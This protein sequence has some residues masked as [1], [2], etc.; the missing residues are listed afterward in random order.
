MRHHPWVSESTTSP[1]RTP[2]EDGESPPPPGGAGPPASSPPPPGATTPPDATAGERDWGPARVLAGLAALLVL[3]LVE[4]GIVI[5]ID[6][7]PSLAPRALATAPVTSGAEPRLFVLNADDDQVWILEPTGNDRLHKADSV[8]VT[9][10]ADVIAVGRLQSAGGP[11]EL[12][13]ANSNSETVQL[14]RERDGEFTPSAPLNVGTH[15]RSVAIGP[16][17]PNGTPVLAV[18]TLAGR[19]ALFRPTGAGRLRQIANLSHLRSLPEAIAIGDVNGDSRPDLLVGAR[20]VVPF[21]ARPSGRLVAEPDRGARAPTSSLALGDLGGGQRAFALTGFAQV[22]V[23]RWSGARGLTLEET[24]DPVDDPRAVAVGKLFDDHADLAV[25]SA[26]GRI[27]VLERSDDGNIDTVASFEAQQSLGARLALQV[28]LAATLALV[29]FTLA[30]PRAG[31]A[32]AAVLG[33]RR[34]LTP[35]W[36][37]AAAAYLAYIGC[38]LVLAALIHPQQDDVTRDLGFGEGGV[39]DL[40]SLIL[41]VVAAP[42]TEEI[43]FR[44]FLFGGLRRALPFVG[45]ALLSGTI[46]GLFHFTGVGSWGVVIQL[47]IF[48]VALAWVYERTGSIWPTIAIHALNNALAFGLLTS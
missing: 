34:S 21:L 3:A 32:H 18:G 20:H 16:L 46:W 5:A 14:Y 13:V 4:A 36:R 45:A 17:G 30:T 48:G 41:I 31:F 24:L 2:V 10:G 40:A 27:E 23:L 29:A 39:G 38:A 26:G 35:P 28:L 6:P 7:A 44:G 9:P 42:V 15:V 33:L 37:P 19:V 43:F 25:S 12:A 22:D 8:E 1:G 47:S 11:L